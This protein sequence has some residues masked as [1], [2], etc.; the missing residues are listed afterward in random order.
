MLKSCDMLWEDAFLNEMSCKQTCVNAIIIIIIYFVL[1]YIQ[2]N[3]LQVK[4]NN[5]RAMCVH[6]H[7]LASTVHAGFISGG[8]GGEGGGGARG[9]FFPLGFSSPAW[10]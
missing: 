4:G 9:C 5:H 7:A 1:I 10:I 8:G 6:M 3:R 2:C